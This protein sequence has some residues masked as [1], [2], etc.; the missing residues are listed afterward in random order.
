MGGV[1]RILLRETLGS[2][3]FVGGGWSMLGAPFATEVFAG[4]PFDYI[5]V[6]CQHGLAGYDRMIDVLGILGRMR[7]VPLVRVPSLDAG[8]VGRALDAGAEGII[9]PMVNGRA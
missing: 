7:P 4:Q 5:V 9:V 2:G 3:G 8:W 6:D 1:P